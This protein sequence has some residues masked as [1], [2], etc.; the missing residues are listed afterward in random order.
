[1]SESL[2]RALWVAWQVAGD[3]VYVSDRSTPLASNR[4]DHW[5]QPA[6]ADLVARVSTSFHVCQMSGNAPNLRVE[7]VE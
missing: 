2:A 3:D 4:Q 7:Q 6:A 1:M 5:S